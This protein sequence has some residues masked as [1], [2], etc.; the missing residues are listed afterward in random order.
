MSSH[1]F[2]KENQEPALIVCSCSSFS[3]ENIE[4]LLEWAPYIIISSQSAEHFYSRGIHFDVCI[5]ETDL[6]FPFMYKSVSL[7]DPSDFIS[8]VLK[9]MA[10]RNKNLNFVFENEDELKVANLQ[11]TIP[12]L[13][14]V[15]FTNDRKWILIHDKIERWYPKNKQVFFSSNEIQVEGDFREIEGTFSMNNEGLL[16]AVGKAEFWLI[17]ELIQDKKA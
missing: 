8:E 12:D 6:N 15:C 14:V 1:H 4:Q 17:E 16:K 5:G 7:K 11:L 2:V 9:E 13:N 3:F 10:D